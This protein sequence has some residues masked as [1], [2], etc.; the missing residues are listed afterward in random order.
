MADHFC[1]ED[2]SGI[3][4]ELKANRPQ[5][6]NCEPFLPSTYYDHNCG[7]YYYNESMM[8]YYVYTMIGDSPIET[9]RPWYS[10]FTDLVE[11]I[12]AARQQHQKWLPQNTT[13]L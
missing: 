13:R 12:D 2:S 11:A 8:G 1:T 10:Q 5:S 4:R 9:Q 6:I 3:W 7:V